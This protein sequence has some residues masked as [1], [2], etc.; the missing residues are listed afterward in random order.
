MWC[1]YHLGR[2]EENNVHFQYDEG[3]ILLLLRH[4][5][6]WKTAVSIL[7]TSISFKHC[8]QQIT[9]H[10]WQLFIHVLPQKTDINIIYLLSTG[11]ITTRFHLVLCFNG[12]GRCRPVHNVKPSIKINGSENWNYCL[13]YTNGKLKWHYSKRPTCYKFSV[14]CTEN[15]KPRSV[16]Q[17]KTGTRFWFKIIKI[18]ENIIYQI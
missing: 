16:P 4:N 15:I 9:S 7:T 8:A 18:F 3:Y 17:C 13:S 11:P 10:K 1:S 14:H 2:R 12:K 5:E 6:T